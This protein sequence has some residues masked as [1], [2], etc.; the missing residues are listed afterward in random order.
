[1]IFYNRKVELN[2]LESK[3]ASNQPELIIF[4]GRRRVGK[5]YLLR[6][7]CTK[8]KGVFFLATTSSSRDNL[9]DF[10]STL[11][12]HYNDERLKISPLQSWDEFFLYINEK[13]IERTI[14]VIDEYSYLILSE[15]SISTIFQKYWDIHLLNNPHIMFI[16]NGS[17][18]SMMEKETLAYRAP[19]FG[20][21]T[22]QWFLEPFDVIASNE[23][24]HYH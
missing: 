9:T 20:R 3:F 24:F 13:T 16:I 18:V 21:R 17:A 10:S 22:G 12:D 15:P 4:W 6:Q 1:M 5:T 14:F 23:F 11:A 7:F 2:Y 8:K 19:L